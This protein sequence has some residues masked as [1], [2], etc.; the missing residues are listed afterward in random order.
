MKPLSLFLQEG[1]VFYA[2]KEGKSVYVKMD[3]S[4]L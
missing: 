1:A 3:W 4:K 2:Q